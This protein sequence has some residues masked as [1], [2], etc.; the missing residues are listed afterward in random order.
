MVRRV[1]VVPV[2]RRAQQVPHVRREVGR[3][4]VGA[5]APRVAQERAEHARVHVRA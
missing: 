4:A 2:G 1:E 3:A 5:L